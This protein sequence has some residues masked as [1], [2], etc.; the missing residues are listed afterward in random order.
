[1]E[2]GTQRHSG[3]PSMLGPSVAQG[4]RAGGRR[5]RSH[6]K[7]SQPWR[8]S[9]SLHTAQ[10]TVPQRPPS[11]P[12]LRFLFGDIPAGRLSRAEHARS[13]G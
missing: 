7:L 8:S 11:I 10:P 12:L 5:W 6:Y 9:G 1:M 13:L 2:P 3:L 4:T